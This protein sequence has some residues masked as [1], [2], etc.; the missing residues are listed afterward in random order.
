[1]PTEKCDLPDCEEL[2]PLKGGGYQFIKFVKDDNG[3]RKPAFFCSLEHL[4]A[5]KRP[6]LN[7]PAVVDSE[8]VLIP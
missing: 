6:D 1:M 7:D 2:I 4:K 8:S 5:D 3:E